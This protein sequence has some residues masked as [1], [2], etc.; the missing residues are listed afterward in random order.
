MTTVQHARLQDAKYTFLIL[1]FRNAI[2]EAE[3]YFNRLGNGRAD[4]TDNYVR[5]VYP[6]R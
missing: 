6:P 2:L 4:A 5:S 1:N 3:I